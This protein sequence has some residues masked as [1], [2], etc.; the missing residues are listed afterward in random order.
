MSLILNT[1]KSRQPFLLLLLPFII[2]AFWI[3]WFSNP[4]IN[5]DVSTQMPFTRFLVEWLKDAP[6]YLGVLSIIVSLVTAY[7]IY[8]V[9]ERYNLLRVGNNLPSLVYILII[10]ALPVYIGFN[11]IVF[12]ALFVLIALVRLMRAYS[13]HMSIACFFDAGFFIGLAAGFY[14]QS[15]LFIIF[16]I[17]GMMSI[18]RFNLRELLAVFL[19][20]LLPFIFIWTYSFYIDD[21]TH[22]YE[23]FSHFNSLSI[24]Y[25]AISVYEWSFIGFIFFLFIVSVGG[26]FLRNPLNEIF[27]IKFYTILFWILLVCL[28]F[29]IFFYPMGFEILLCASIPLSFFIGRYFAIQRHKWLGDMLFILLIVCA[30]VLQF[31]V[32]LNMIYPHG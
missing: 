29:P 2:S 7:T 27:E 24:A 14:L 21:L 10:G 16:I 26:F 25:D 28:M 11:P 18:G 8:Y 22:L 9:V 5:I 6:V 17:I 12:S 32:L 1:F 4:I 31:P 30:F 20:L 23:L 15:L 3:K 19:G 13:E